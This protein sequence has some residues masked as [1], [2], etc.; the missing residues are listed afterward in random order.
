MNFRTAVLLAALTALFGVVGNI[1]AG[2]GGMLIALAI[3]LGMNVM[4]YWNA[5]KVV[6]RL[7]GAREVGEAEVPELY[8]I[9]REIATKAGLP[10]PRVFIMD[11]PQPNAFATGRN[12]SHAVVAATTGLLQHLSRQEVAGVLAHELAHVKNRDTLTMTIAATLGGAI[13]YLANMAQFGLIF[14]SGRSRDRRGGILATL[15]VVFLAPLAA[16][17]V[18]MAIS[19]SREYEADR[20]GALITGHPLWLA[21]ALAKLEALKQ[22][23]P[24]EVAE[25]TPAMAHLYIVNPLS[26]RGIDNLFSTHPSTSNRIAALEQL[27]RELGQG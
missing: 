15:L 25:A 4:T 22:E 17:L 19:R 27:A 18:Q 20:A 12:P 2:Q 10:M 24:N 21:S 14:G 11:N 5:D 9:V 16:G 26:G 1:I 6:L 13:G 23:I 3:A 7:Q 8:A